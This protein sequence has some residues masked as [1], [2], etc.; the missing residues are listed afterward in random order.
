MGPRTSDENNGHFIET[1]SVRVGTSAAGVGALCE[2]FINDSAF[3]D[4]AFSA[5]KMADWLLRKMAESGYTV[6]E[7][8]SI[9]VEEDRAGTL[10]S[11]LRHL[12][13]GNHSA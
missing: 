9:L 11:Y 1:R 13:A 5:D 8:E 3:N 4:S 2:L 10:S 12:A 6:Q 7:L